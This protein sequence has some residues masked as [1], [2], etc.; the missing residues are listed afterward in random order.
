MYVHVWIIMFPPVMEYRITCSHLS[1]IMGPLYSHSSGIAVL[2]SVFFCFVSSVNSVLYML[3]CM[4]TRVCCTRMFLL[5]IA[6]EYRTTCAY[7]VST[8]SHMK[9]NVN[10]MCTYTECEFSLL[11]VRSVHTYGLVFLRIGCAM[12][13]METV[14]VY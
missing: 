9:L 2:P 3:H 11:L 8:C 12:C 6:S 14:C 1:E 7:T 4:C 5:V 10:T 13:T